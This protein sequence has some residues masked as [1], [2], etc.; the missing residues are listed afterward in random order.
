MTDN[1]FDISDPDTIARSDANENE[2]E[3]TASNYE[4]SASSSLSGDLNA[5]DAEKFIEEIES[6]QEYIQITPVR[7]EVNSETVKRELYGLH[8]Y[9]NGR[10]LPLDMEL[11][12]AGIEPVANFEFIIYKPEDEAQFKFFIG[13]GERGD[14]TCDRL[15]GT[16]RSQYP[17]NFEFDREQFDITNVFDEVPEMIRWEGVEEKRRDWMTT[18]TSYNNEAIERSPLSNLLETIIQ[19]DGSV[20]FRVTQN[21][22]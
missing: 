5:D 9:G 19:T 13:P 8:R 3:N 4:T 10:K 1:D 16:T 14:V 18:L 20:I 7:E 11:H 2:L 22:C 12:I 6:E 17:E 15:E 21:K